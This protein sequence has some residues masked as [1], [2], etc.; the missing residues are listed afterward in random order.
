MMEIY[1]E[2]IIS[3]GGIKG[4]SLIGALN[5][6]CKNYPINKIKYYTGCSVG[7][8]ILLLLNLGYTIND[9]KNIFFNINFGSF[10]E[11]K[12]INLLEKCGFDEGLKFMDFLKAV[13]LNKNYNINITFQELHQLTNKVL[14]VAVTNITKGIVEYH[15]YI[16][17]PN[18]NVILSIRMSCNIPILFSP[19]IYNNCYYVDGAL[20]EPFPYYYHKNTKKIGI[21]LC[22]KFEFDFIK[23]SYGNVIV[24]ISDSF[25]Y[26]FD[27][28]KIVYMNYMKKSYKNLPKNMIYIVNDLNVNI[29][30]FEVS[31]NDKI[32]MY[33]NGMNAANIFLKKKYKK[34]RKIFLLKKY[35][36]KLKKNN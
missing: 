7:S 13:L 35:F 32:K 31:I 10:Q 20:L 11:C 24:D 9:I 33:N 8:F 36:N 29:D 34:I 14:T 2:L 26:I 28:L 30:S 4:I 25:K 23:K 17:T 21:W 19:A 22:E 15:N 6:L 3:S 1:E 18:L 12:L 27:I 5:Q 16:N